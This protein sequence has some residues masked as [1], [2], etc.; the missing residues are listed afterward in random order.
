MEKKNGQVSKV[1]IFDHVY[2]IRAEKEAEYI[3]TLAEFVD[4][5]MREI[6]RETP[7][8]DTLRVAILTALNIA[9]DY[10]QLQRRFK[11]TDQTIGQKALGCVEV[12]DQILN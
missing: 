1:K 12:L 7:T 6:S 9:D 2:S 4:G 11:E 5:R 10:F 8:V 3:A